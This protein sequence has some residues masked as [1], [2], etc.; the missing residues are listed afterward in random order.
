[1]AILAEASVSMT[2][3]VSARIALLVWRWFSKP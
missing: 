1:M 2:E 3:M